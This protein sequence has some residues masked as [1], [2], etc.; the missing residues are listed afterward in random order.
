MN[1]NDDRYLASLCEGIDELLAMDPAPDWNAA[2][3]FRV[4]EGHSKKVTIGTDG[5]PE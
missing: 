2:C 1:S 3:H 5:G 4:G